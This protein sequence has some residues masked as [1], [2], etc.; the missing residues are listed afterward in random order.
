MSRLVALLRSLGTEGAARNA[1]VL[2]DQRSREGLAVEALA[3]TMALAPVG[4][5]VTAAA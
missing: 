2:L 5:R 1:R 4:P 3:A